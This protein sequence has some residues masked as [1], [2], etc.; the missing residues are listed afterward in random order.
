MENQLDAFMEGEDEL[1]E[2][3]RSLQRPIRRTPVAP[4]RPSG[5]PPS[6]V[7]IDRDRS[8]G[9]PPPVTTPLAAL[10]QPVCLNGHLPRRSPAAAGVGFAPAQTAPLQ[11]HT[12]PHDRRGGAAT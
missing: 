2:R 10:S 3:P 1:S 11:P 5:S 9:R 4:G 7:T 8:S 6:S 12:R